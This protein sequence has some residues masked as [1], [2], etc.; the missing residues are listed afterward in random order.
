MMEL[1]HQLVKIRV[2]P[3]YIYQCDLSQGLTHFRTSIKKGLEIMEALIG[4]TSGFCVPSFVVDAPAG[5]GKIRVMPNYVISMSDHT[6][7]LRNYEGVIVAY[8]EPE[9]TTSD[10]DDSEYREKYKFSGV[11]SL[12]TDKKISIEPAHLERHERIRMWK[13]RKKA[14]E[15]KNETNAVENVGNAV[16]K[17][18]TNV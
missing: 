2:R 10:V 17:E 9:D 14:E 15:I 1:V 5:G 13:E 11:A 16:K 7:I 4:H 6:V 8:H 3:Y 18:E 12:F